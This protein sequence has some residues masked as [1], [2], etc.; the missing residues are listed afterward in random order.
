MS[1]IVAAG[2]GPRT[3]RHHGQTKNA[4]LLLTPLDLSDLLIARRR[5]GDL[6]P[7]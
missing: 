3:V 7:H 2:F 1:Y 4:A 6:Q 5:L